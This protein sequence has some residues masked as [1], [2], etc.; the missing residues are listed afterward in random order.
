MIV[1]LI[2]SH[3]E[4][5]AFIAGLVGRWESR[6]G[7]ADCTEGKSGEEA[8]T[9][10]VIGMGQPHAAR[11][12]RAVLV[13]L[14]QRNA[15]FRGVILA[16]FAGALNPELKRGEIFVTAGAAHLLPL[17]AAAERPREAKLATVD[18][19]A[20]TAAAK[21]ELFER[22]GAWLCDMEQAHLEPLAQEFGVP[23]VGLRIVSDEAHEDLPV[24]T[25][26]RSYDQQTG[27]YTPW[28]LAGYLA[29]HPLRIAKLAAFVRLLPPVRNCL[30]DRLHTWL[31]QAGP[32]LFR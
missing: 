22:T 13:D 7:G 3:F 14:K 15:N 20:G 1:V 30:S 10:G 16:G 8:V 27:T 25:L 11:R 9:V 24:E 18:K 23:F 26:G 28:K 2:P 6:I 17:L 12:A 5:K 4:A 32:R 29:L 19:I 31:R 21:R